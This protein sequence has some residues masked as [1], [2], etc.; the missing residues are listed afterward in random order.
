MARNVPSS[1]WARLW[2]MP[3]SRSGPVWN[4]AMDHCNG[5]R[6]MTLYAEAR[7]RAAFVEDGARGNRS[8]KPC[9]SATL[10]GDPR[11]CSPSWTTAVPSAQPSLLLR[12]TTLGVKWPRGRG[13]VKSDKFQ[14]VS[15]VKG[16]KR[17]C[18]RYNDARGCPGCSDLHACDVKLPSGKA[19]LSPNHNRLSHQEW[20]TGPLPRGGAQLSHLPGHLC[21]LPGQ[22]SMAKTEFEI[23]S[24]KAQP[25]TVQLRD[26]ALI[27]LEKKLYAAKPVTW[28]GKGDLLQCPW[29]LV[30]K[31]TLLVIDLWSGYGGLPIALLT[32]GCSFYCL[33]AEMDPVA[34]E[35]SAA[36]MP[37]IVHVDKVDQVRG[38]MLSSIL[39]RRKP[40][41]IVIGGGSPCQGNTALNLTRKGLDDPRSQEPLEIQRIEDEIKALPEAQGIPVIRFLENVGSMP[42][43]VEAT[44]TEWLGF[45]PVRIEAL[46]C[47]WARRNR[48]YWLGS[49]SGGINPTMTLPADWQWAEGSES[50]QLLYT[51][52]K[53]I[54]SKIH[55]LDGFGPM[56]DPQHILAGNH[57]LGFHPFTREF[58]HPEDRIHQSSPEAVARF[59][60]DARRF[61]P[62]AYEEQSLLWRQDEW[63]QPFPSE[64]AQM[65]GVPP[66][67]VAAV[68]ATMPKKRQL[69]N[70][71]I[72]NGFHL[73]SI[74]ILL[75]LLPQLLEA[76][77]TPPLTP[78]GERELHQRIVNTVWEP[79]RIDSFPGLLSA[80]SLTDD[81]KVTFGQFEVDAP[82]WDTILCRLQACRL[83]QLQFFSAWTRMQGHEW[84]HLGP[85]PVTSRDRAAIYAGLSGQR[86]PSSSSRGI[87]HLL[88]PGLGPEA[89]MEEAQRQPSPFTPSCWPETDVSFVV[90][91]VVV[92]REYLP[93]LAAKL[94][95]T[96]KTVAQALEPLETK[97]HTFRSLSAR[98][99]AAGKKPAFIAAMSSLLK[100]PDRLQAINLLRGYNIVGEFE[101]SGIF[102]P[103][104]AAAPRDL[105]TWLG[106]EAE[107]A[108]A[109]ILHSRPPRFADDILKVTLEEQERGFCGPFM[110]KMEVD[111]LFGLGRWR[112]LERFLI[113]QADGKLRMIDNARR[114]GH[115]ACTLLH[116]TITT[117]NVDCIA[118]FARMVCDALRVEKSPCHQYP[119]LCLKIGTDDLADAY[120]GLPVSEDHTRF[121]VVAIYLPQEGWRFTVLYGLAYGLGSAVVS[122]NRLPQLGVAIA[123]RTCLS[124]AASYFDDQLAVEFFDFSNVS[125]LGLRLSFTAMGAPPQ[126]AK[127]FS[128]ATNRHY[129]GTS[130]HVGDFAHDGCIRF[131]PKSSTQFKVLAHIGQA[132]QNTSMDRDTASKLRG[133]LNWMW[134]NCSGQVG[135]FAG[136][137]LTEIQAQ[138]TSQLTDH[139]ITSLRILQ[140]IVQTA[141]PRDIHVCGSVRPLAVVYSD[142][143]FEA[144]QLRLGWI[145]LMANCTPFGGS[146]VVPDEVLNSWTPRK[147]QI[148]PGETLCGLIVPW[149]HQD[150]LRNHDILW[151]VDNE[152]AVSALI[153]GSSSQD[154]VHLIA[155]F[156]NLLTHSL[157]CRAWYEWIDSGSNPSDGLSREGI[158]DPWTA[159]QGWDIR[160]YP[161]PH[162]LHP[163]TFLSVFRQHL[164]LGDSGWILQ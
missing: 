81:L 109:N 164:N 42:K 82:L 74:L 149:F 142:A 65:M 66:S 86:H 94:R 52:K 92:W 154:D 46:G 116:E 26:D 44:Y 20:Q 95:K 31:G 120:R 75:C 137:V 97:L 63:R 54:P 104:K 40:R 121:S 23:A 57:K 119:W 90:Q 35:A 13:E 153:R 161:F 96:L 61:P 147:Q 133:D 132:L 37:N 22:P 5:S 134:S 1:P 72:G 41:C 101:S 158:S 7:W 3:T 8:E 27:S 160:G 157:N 150:R 113:K 129:L 45:P 112:P 141:S 60:E 33:S 29:V 80:R 76:K 131:Q 143:S 111:H 17:I 48:L 155:Q 162:L 148:F 144:G 117:V 4:G 89:H 24:E 102:R 84:Q 11:R 151:F 15:M 59:R 51:G 36:T 25:R 70:S 43:N 114:T 64:R 47:G 62:S 14:T 28:R 55:W 140:S 78:L 53:P 30:P 83:E 19:C 159:T 126:P 108:I 93:Q 118:S 9:V 105:E 2:T 77:V 49:S 73:P 56:F 163:S 136:P 87:D 125:Q 85:I 130:I 67:A 115:N 32:M 71:L 38:P 135:R 58:S 152:G 107:T 12:P 146:C 88:P 139:A 122:F 145:V 10:I 34:R 106:T 100:W 110:T 156:S 99:V 138:T 124:F 103:I 127:A 98:Q 123:R 21:N 6:R 79:G 18:K 39:S 69:Q 91:A 68:S 128:P 16:G 50:Y